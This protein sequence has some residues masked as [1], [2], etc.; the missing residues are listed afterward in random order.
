MYCVG[1]PW[2]TQL[3]LNKSLAQIAQGNGISF[4]NF[5]NIH[6]ST[7]QQVDVVR[8]DSKAMPI[9]GKTVF[10]VIRFMGQ[11]QVARYS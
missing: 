11:D 6:F 4:S 2:A 1:L 9:L 7:K 8:D 3:L 5:T 10:I